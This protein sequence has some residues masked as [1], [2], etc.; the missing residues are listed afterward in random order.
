MLSAPRMLQQEDVARVAL[1]AHRSLLGTPWSRSLKR[2]EALHVS[3]SRDEEK[4]AELA[5]QLAAMSGDEAVARLA[6]LRAGPD[7]SGPCTLSDKRK[8][9]I[10]CMAHRRLQDWYQDWYKSLQPWPAKTFMAEAIIDAIEKGLKRR[11]RVHHRS[12]ATDQFLRQHREDPDVATATNEVRDEFRELTVE[13]VNAQQLTETEFQTK[14]QALLRFAYGECLTGDS[15]LLAMYGDVKRAT[16]AECYES[17]AALEYHGISHDQAPLSDRA[18]AELVD[19]LAP[20]LQLPD[21]KAWMQAQAV[22]DDECAQRHSLM[23]AVVLAERA[24]HSRPDGAAAFAQALFQRRLAGLRTRQAASRAGTTALWS[25]EEHADARNQFVVARQKWLADRAPGAADED[26]EEGS[27][28]LGFT[29][30][31]KRSHM[32]AEASAWAPP[33]PRR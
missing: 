11:V 9:E 10:R 23:R 4:S 18:L 32:S 26:D 24:R 3:P 29:Q 15:G 20:Q 33:S 31:S 21:A 14:R 16:M 7:E 13:W 22:G 17:A 1:A 12:G 27:A 6:E 8:E 2:A 30:V 25:R 5:Q 28:A 19:A